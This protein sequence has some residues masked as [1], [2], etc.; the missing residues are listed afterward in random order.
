MHD[1]Q[2]GLHAT[3]GLCVLRMHR[4]SPVRGLPEHPW[5]QAMPICTR[6]TMR[7]TPPRLRAVQHDS[8]GRQDLPPARHQHRLARVPGAPPALQGQIS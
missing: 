5:K 1:L 7:Q 2:R 4:G 3:L 8:G 6:L